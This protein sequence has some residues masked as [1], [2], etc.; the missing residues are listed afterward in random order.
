MVDI[1]TDEI[2]AKYKLLS[3]NLSLK[4]NY[5]DDF[6]TYIEFAQ[7]DDFLD[8]LHMGNV[9]IIRD[10]NFFFDGEYHDCD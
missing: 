1:Y 5:I 4:L 7:D 6:D 3:D 9:H 10:S 8:F 2:Q